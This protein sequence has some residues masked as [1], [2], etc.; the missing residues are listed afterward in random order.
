MDADSQIDADCARGTEV[1]PAKRIS[2]IQRVRAVREIQDAD[3]HGCLSPTAAVQRLGRRDVK[4]RA[5]SDAAGFKA[6]D[7]LLTLDGRWTDS[8]AD[9]Y[10]A[11]SRLQPGAR[12]A[13]EVLRDGKKQ[14]LKIEVLS[15]L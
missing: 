12:V 13:A 1:C 10:F 14:T 6:G 8:V 2:K 11:A 5:R 4:D 15:G 7:R 3:A 9:C